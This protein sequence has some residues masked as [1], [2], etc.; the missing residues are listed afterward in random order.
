MKKYIKPILLHTN[1]VNGI[2]PVTMAAM[3]SAALAAGVAAAVSAVATT[4]AK[5]L[6]GDNFTA[7]DYLPALEPVEG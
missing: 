6:S 5:Q 4:I 1:S 3:G 2:V 7:R